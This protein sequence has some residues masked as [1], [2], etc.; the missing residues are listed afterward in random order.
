MAPDP[1]SFVLG[2]KAIQ[3]L[4]EADTSA[5]AFAFIVLFESGAMLLLESSTNGPHQSRTG[6]MLLKIA[7]TAQTSR[8]LVLLAIEKSR[9]S[10]YDVPFSRDG[11]QCSLCSLLMTDGSVVFMLTTSLG[12]MKS[13][14][15]RITRLAQL[16]GEKPT[17][18]A[19]IA[20][21]A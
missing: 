11:P 2:G 7:Q 4:V 18:V 9:G 19:A 14:C 16:D 15:K 6:R 17:R 20:Q 3:D 21:A 12:G 8:A 10:V 5:D 1:A 13:I